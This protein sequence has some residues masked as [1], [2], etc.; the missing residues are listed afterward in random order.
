[1]LWNP[2][3]A[4][5][6]GQ[7]DLMMLRRLVVLTLAMLC[8]SPA[9]AG[10]DNSIEVWKSDTCSCCKNW[11]KHLEANGFAVKVNAADPSV[12]DHIKRASGI[13][14]KIASCHTAKIDGYVIEGH[15]PAPD[16][17]RLVADHPD[18]LGLTVPGMPIGAP[19]MEQGAESEPYDVL[20]VKKDGTTEI[21]SRH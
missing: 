21:F 16:I 2:C 14:E 10:I 18:A 7:E 13:G 17:N 8:A 5:L 15:V 1:L 3:E 11:V 6:T 9:F 4:I 12:L 19:G 20:L